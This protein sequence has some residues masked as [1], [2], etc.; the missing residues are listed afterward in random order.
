MEADSGSTMPRYSSPS[1]HLRSIGVLGELGLDMVAVMQR[2]AGIGHDGFVDVEALEDFRQ[3][4]GHQ[5]NLDPACFD[6]IPF[7][8]LDGQMVNGG[9]RD[10]NVAAAFGVD[11][12]LG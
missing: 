11:A 10:R 5:S 1:A 9:T 2:G 4:V 8:H 7:D 12:G 3:F 6:R